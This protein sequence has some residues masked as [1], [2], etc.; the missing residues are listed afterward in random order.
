MRNYIS[1]AL[2]TTPSG[3]GSHCKRAGVPTRLRI[4]NRL[5]SKCRA[6]A[7]TGARGREERPKNRNVRFQCAFQCKTKKWMP[8]FRGGVRDGPADVLRDPVIG[9]GG[10]TVRLRRV[11]GS[12]RHAVWQVPHTGHGARAED[13]IAGE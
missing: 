1:L 2:A 4:G 7:V 9:P 6:T 12:D 13:W 3:L 10:C 5:R 8:V 11:S